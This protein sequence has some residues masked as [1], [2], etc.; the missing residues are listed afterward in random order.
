M[1]IFFKS[2][3]TEIANAHFLQSSPYVIRSLSGCRKICIIRSAAAHSFLVAAIICWPK[4]FE[5]FITVVRR[6]AR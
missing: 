5:P 3:I 1:L 4:Q 6:E 2:P